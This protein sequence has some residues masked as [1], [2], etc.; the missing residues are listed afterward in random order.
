M[1]RRRWLTLAFD[2]PIGGNLTRTHHYLL[3]VGNYININPSTLTK[4]QKKTEKNEVIGLENL[5]RLNLYV[6]D[7]S[8]LLFAFTSEINAF[9]ASDFSV[10]P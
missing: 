9:H 2:F 6:Q 5:D 7:F 1:D 4:T 3:S 8:R 10:I